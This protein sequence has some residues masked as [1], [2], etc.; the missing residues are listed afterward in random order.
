M[1]KGNGENDGPV[2]TAIKMAIINF[3]YLK[4]SL[5]D[6]DALSLGESYRRFEESLCLG[7][8]GLRRESHTQ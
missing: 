4:F 5:L 3:L 8:Q 6:C 1:S 2:N 7:L